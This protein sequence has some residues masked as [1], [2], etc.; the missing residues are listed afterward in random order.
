MANQSGQ[1]NSATYDVI[2]IGAGSVGTPAAFSLAE[3]GIRALVIDQQPSVGQGSNK[4][5]IGGI[6]ATHSDPAKIRLCLRSIEIFSAWRERYGDDIEWYKGGY[7]FV[8]Y[9][10]REEKT[11]KDLLAIQKPYGL[12]ID[13]LDK[14]A[15]LEVIP[16]L[17]PR[18][19]I[20]GTFSPEDGNASPLLAAHAF[21]TQARR[22]GTEFR[23]N[24]TVTDILVSGGRVRG[25]KTDK[26]EYGA[27]VV[28]NAAGA[29][30]AP[31]AQMVGLDVPV[32]PD[33]HEAAI[34][35]P[36]T[37]FLDPMVVDIRPVAGSANYYFYQHYTGQIVFCIT[38][39]PSI[40]GQD[41]RETSSFLPMIARRMVDVMPRLKNIRVRRTWRGLYPMTP[42]GF[43]LVGWA[44]E[45]EGF[46][47]AV[48]MCGQGLMLG[49]GLGELLTRM[50][51]NDVTKEDQEALA[52]LSPH[53]QFAGQEKLK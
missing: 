29:W 53:R 46:L 52:L 49:P 39:S 10:E 40:W 33:S 13:W 28:I 34:T 8:A 1:G 23:F 43:P 18:G 36:V 21:Y 2:I 50:V 22:L 44:K 12:N 5:A 25:V 37:R 19:L 9:T 32:K 48:G 7:A 31:I 42:D 11:L 17:N 3:A 26:G 16:D 35:E 20:G 30:A 6:R 14:D 38:P 4:A 41:T 45:V 15:L 24:E 27:D 51:K 47:V